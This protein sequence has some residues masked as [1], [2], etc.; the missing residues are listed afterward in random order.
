MYTKKPDEVNTMGMD[1]NANTNDHKWIEKE[2]PP[3]KKAMKASQI[4]TS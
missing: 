4:K 2:K 3:L 1:K